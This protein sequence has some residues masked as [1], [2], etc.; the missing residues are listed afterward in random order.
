MSKSPCPL[1]K[2]HLYLS[3]IFTVSFLC[4]LL[5]MTLLYP[6]I[7]QFRGSQV[8]QKLTC[9]PFLLLF[10]IA[11]VI[12]QNKRQVFILCQFFSSIEW[13][14]WFCHTA[15]STTLNPQC[16]IIQCMSPPS[17]V[18]SILTLVVRLCTLW[19]E[20]MFYLLEHSLIANKKHE[21]GVERLYL[22][23]SE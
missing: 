8:N 1:F 23:I 4:L 3:F 2:N 7:F 14:L 6:F 11:K 16:K 13:A 22:I 15:K 10:Q 12:K 21:F 20:K 5:F 9:K 17:L 19:Y 18:T